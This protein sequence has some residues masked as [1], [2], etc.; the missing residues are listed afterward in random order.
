MIKYFAWLDN[1]RYFLT[2]SISA[3]FFT[4]INYSFKAHHMFKKRFLHAI[5][6]ACTLLLLAPACQKDNDS[7]KV[8]AVGPDLVF[9]GVTTSNQLLQYNAKSPGIVDAT[10][11][12]TGLQTGETLLGIDFRPATGQLYGVGSTSRL[13]IINHLT[14]RATVV[15]A[16]PFT[17]AL[18]G[19]I[20]AFDFNPTVDRIRVVTSSGQNLRL[21]PETSGTAT[22]DGSINP[23]SPA[24]SAVAYTN[25][26]AGATS[27]TLFDIDIN[28]KKL[29][30]QDPPN[31]GT[32]V[33]VGP[34]NLDALTDGG[35][36]I[37]PNNGV[38]LA[39][40]TVAGSNKLYMI[41]ITTGVATDLGAFATPVTGIAIPTNSVAYSVDESNNLLVFDFMAS[42]LPISKA[43]MG[44]QPN[45]MILGID[46]RPANGQL[47]ALGSSS[48]VYTLNLATGAATVV[49]GQ[50]STLLNGTSFGFDF[51]PTVDRIRVVSNT[52]QNL[53]LD[54]TTAAV[55]IDGTLNPGTPMI[56]AAAYTNN[57]PG[58]TTTTL[59]DID[60]GT[61]KL[62]IQTPP[63]NGT[64]AEVGSLG[65]NVELNNGF[66]IG[67][68]SN[69]A[70][71]LLRVGGLTKMYSINLTTGAASLFSEFP[72][73]VRGLAIGLG[74]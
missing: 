18:N 12:I 11:A 43:I 68:T 9:Y 6:C 4:V 72:S 71:A 47:Y 42:G 40:L 66:D 64:L 37:S 44:L 55:T 69:K 35:F 46:M 50:L 21:N 38:A 59:F 2:N 23:G 26:F 48:R 32:L 22:V 7:Q 36:D 10:V 51:N 34:L 45:E 14:G 27:T 41:D 3:V 17:P 16:G 8:E 1:C 61:D 20:V 39:S 62:Y 58:A 74:F 13:Y 29:F 60:A 25:N 70:Y 56:S 24:I 28:T 63:N 73:N 67:G 54:P 52:G 30:R 31:N 5:A 49:G 33:E 53:R 57:F 65:I 19:T 15:G